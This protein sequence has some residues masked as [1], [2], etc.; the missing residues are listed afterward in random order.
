[1][2]LTTVESNYIS[3]VGQA[4]AKALS[5]FYEE[6]VELDTLWAGT[7]G[8]NTSIT[9]ANIDATNGFAKAALTKQQVADAQ[10]ALSNMKS[11]IANALPALAIMRNIS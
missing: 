7:P 6:L 2:A 11:A 1:M 8:L 10:T 5:G 4:S 9:Q 3:R